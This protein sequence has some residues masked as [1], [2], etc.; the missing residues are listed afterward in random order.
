MSYTTIVLF[1][2]AITVVFVRGSIFHLIR[3]HGP[4]LWKEF[5]TCALCVGVWVGAGVAWLVERRGGLST[6]FPVLFTALALGSLTGVLA[7]LY[8]RVVDWLESSAVEKDTA[9]AVNVLRA[10][11]LLADLKD[12][13]PNA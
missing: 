7:L 1:S 9:E 4:E 3:T 5:A 10:K 8:V 13:D 6:G 11:I 12:K 2:A